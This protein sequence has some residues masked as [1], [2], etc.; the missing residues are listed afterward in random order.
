MMDG[1]DHAPLEVHLG[2]LDIRI[3]KIRAIWV[4]SK[5]EEFNKNV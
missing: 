5:G 1:G 4:Q 2:N 3:W